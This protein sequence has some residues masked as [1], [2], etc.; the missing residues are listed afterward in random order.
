MFGT[1]KQRSSTPEV[2]NT[3]RRKFLKWS[4]FGGASLVMG[5]L[6]G[7]RL[8]DLI[9]KENI[10]GEILNQV[11]LKNF[12]MVETDNKLSI[13]DRNNKPVI[14]IDKEDG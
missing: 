11:N 3:H 10:K 1:R 9:Q 8:N 14:S 12:Q 4:A 7:N 13:Y 5:K 2:Q 6:F